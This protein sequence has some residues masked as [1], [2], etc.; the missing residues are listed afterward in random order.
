MP[1]PRIYPVIWRVPPSGR[2]LSGKAQVDFLRQY[3]REAVARSAA[4]QN[5]PI[6]SFDTDSSGAPIAVD[7]IYWSL[8][9]KPDYVAGVAAKHPTGIDI[10]KIRPVEKR[11]FDRVINASERKLLNA[12]P[13]FLFFR[14]WTA[15]EVVLKRMGVGLAGLSKC[16]VR[17]VIDDYELCVDYQ[18]AGFTVMQ[19]F[20]DDYIAAVLKADAEVIEWQFE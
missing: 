12:D 9:H 16:R 4:I 14:F 7:G 20:F 6:R 2:R 10:E 13:N 5:L 15:K 11:L 17:R 18:A 1:T 19:T 8:S 3:A